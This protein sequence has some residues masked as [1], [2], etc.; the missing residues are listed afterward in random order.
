MRSAAPKL[1]ATSE[2]ADRE[3]RKRLW[4]DPLFEDLGTPDALQLAKQCHVSLRLVGQV[5]GLIVNLDSFLDVGKV[6]ASHAGLSDYIKN[7]NGQRISDRQVRRA[8]EFLR[9][10]GHLRVINCRGTVNQMFPLYRQQRPATAEPVATTSPVEDVAADNASNNK[11]IMSEHPGHDVQ[12]VRT[13]CPPKLSTKPDIKLN[14]PEPPL[15]QPSGTVVRLSEYVQAEAA[16]PEADGRKLSAV[17][18]SFY[19]GRRRRSASTEA[20]RQFEQD[21]EWER[22]FEGM[23]AEILEPEPSGRR[24]RRRRRNSVTE[25]NDRHLR[26]LYER[27]QIIDVTPGA[28][29]AHASAPTSPRAGELL[30][31]DTLEW[32]AERNR[33]IAAGMKVKF[34]DRCAEWKIP[35]TYGLGF[36]P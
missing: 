7:A 10:R 29:A 36:S 11:D 21:R 2:K 17:D 20:R 19:R 4:L 27:E 22:S 9:E 24:R 16:E 3:R 32:H 13:S 18:D 23:Q 35:W 28:N 15:S 14:P 6:W 1:F 34:M 25:A 33:R 26:E 5:A 30:Q 8:V 31:P 12:E